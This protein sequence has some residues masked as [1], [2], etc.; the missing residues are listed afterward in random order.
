MCYPTEKKPCVDC[1]GLGFIDGQPCQRCGAS[2][3]IYADWR[4]WVAIL[5]TGNKNQDRNMYA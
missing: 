4:T 2:G 5:G 3:H 1:G